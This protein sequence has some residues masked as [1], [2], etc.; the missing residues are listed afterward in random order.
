[1]YR[2]HPF[3][4]PEHLKAVRKAKAIVSIE[5]TEG[6]KHFVQEAE[7]LIQSMTP[8]VSM[9]NDED[10]VRIASQITFIS[11]VKRC[12]GLMNKQKDLLATYPQP[13][14]PLSY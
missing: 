4:D 6:W 1:M 7:A 5:E 10:A 3:R 14:D 8:E 11:G 13:E 2:P 9:F 12:L